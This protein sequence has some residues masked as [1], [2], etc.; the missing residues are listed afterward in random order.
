MAFTLTSWYLL[1]LCAVIPHL[2]LYNQE[3]HQ[4]IKKTILLC[5]VWLTLKTSS[6]SRRLAIMLRPKWLLVKIQ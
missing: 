3:I 5:R 2:D 1:T 6:L 4:N